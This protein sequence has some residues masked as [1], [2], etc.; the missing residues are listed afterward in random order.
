MDQMRCIFLVG[1]MASGKSSVGA[2]VAAR[3]GARF[4]DLDEEITREL[5]API[6]EIFASQGEATFRAAESDA[7]VTVVG[8]DDVV[9]AAGGGAFCSDRNLEII[10]GSGGVSVYLDLPWSELH[11]RLARDHSG[12]PMYDNPEQAARLFEERR[13]QYLKA[14]ARVV[15][16][17]TEGADEVADRVVDALQEVPCA[18]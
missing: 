13:P 5:R 11:R 16:D 9:V 1:F 12:R 7:L 10:H 6:A 15:L 4:I 14:M 8:I 2:V 3:L 17:G 18:T